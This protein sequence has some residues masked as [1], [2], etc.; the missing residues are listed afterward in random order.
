MSRFAR[1]SPFR[2]SISVDSQVKER[3]SCERTARKP[4]SAD[5]FPIACRSSDSRREGPEIPS[6]NVEF[7]LSTPSVQRILFPMLEP[8]QSSIES[9]RRITDLSFDHSQSETSVYPI[10]NPIGFNISSASFVP[11]R[12][13]S[14]EEE[15]SWNRVPILRLQ[16]RPSVSHR[17]PLFE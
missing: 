11:I 1:K 9:P 2:S 17:N 14:E 4:I 3:R 8:Q 12:D 5:T 15:S 6:S 7:I 13:D 16:P 10:L